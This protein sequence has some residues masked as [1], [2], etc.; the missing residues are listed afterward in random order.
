MMKKR[1]RKLKGAFVEA[2][3]EAGGKTI[4]FIRHAQ[5]Q[6]NAS[7]DFRADDF[8][9]PLVPLSDLGLKQAEGVPEYFKQAP[10]L[11]IT[12]P[13]IRTKQTAKHLI[14][15][16]PSVPQEEWSIHEFTYLSVDKCFNTTFSER[17]PLK[18]AY[19]DK[20]DPDYNDGKGA[21]SFADFINRTRNAI[22]ELKN[23]KE[24]F[25]VLFSHEYTIA[26]AKYIIEKNPQKITPETMKDYREYFRENRIGNASKVEFTL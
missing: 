9:V 22:E 26:L 6:A 24:Q 5:S 18:D 4:W 7:A 12:S 2:L 10:D 19:W 14:N 1:K 20:S 16:Y 21:E 23:R 11:I 25:I 3:K 13:Y 8:S 17:K 15:K